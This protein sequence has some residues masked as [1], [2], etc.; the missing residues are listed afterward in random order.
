MPPLHRTP[1]FL[2]ARS[3]YNKYNH[4]VK[5]QNL[6]VFH[7]H[8]V[9]IPRGP[10]LQS[11]PRKM[12]TI[13]RKGVICLVSAISFILRERTLNFAKPLLALLP[14]GK[15]ITIASLLIEKFPTSATTMA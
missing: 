9:R 14:Y 7:R 2:T 15:A 1:L 8:R 3:C 5:D 11:R 10:V 13:L 6:D 4:A 12:K